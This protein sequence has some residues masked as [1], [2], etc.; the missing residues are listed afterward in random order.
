MS[1]DTIFEDFLF[2]QRYMTFMHTTSEHR[3]QQILEKGFVFENDFSKTT[4]YCLPVNVDFRWYLLRRR[5]LGDAVVILH[6]TADEKRR[7]LEQI[8]FD[9]ANALV[10]DG[11]FDAS[12]QQY[13]LP[14]EH[15]KGYILRNED[16]IRNAYFKG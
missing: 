9:E 1:L 4:D 15:I 2:D 6:L 8:T 13:V 14:R 3:A 10:D 12:Q 5:P 7:A 11:D 16:I